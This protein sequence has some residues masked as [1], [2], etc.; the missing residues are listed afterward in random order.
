V[1]APHGGGHEVIAFVPVP[2]E[3]VQP[4][5]RAAS[6]P[7]S[8]CGR[9]RLANAQLVLHTHRFDGTTVDGF[10]SDRCLRSPGGRDRG[11]AVG[12]VIAAALASVLSRA[13]GRQR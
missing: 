5:L 9:A 11:A 1:H 4:F 7:V 8:N 3:N 12:V 13:Q 10:R 2:M 6:T